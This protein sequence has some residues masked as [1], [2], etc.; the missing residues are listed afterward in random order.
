MTNYSLCPQGFYN[1]WEWSYISKPLA[2]ST[3]ND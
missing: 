2:M 1:P 3:Y